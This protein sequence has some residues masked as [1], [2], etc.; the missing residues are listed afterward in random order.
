VNNVN[1]AMREAYTKACFSLGM[2]TRKAAETLIFLLGKPVSAQTVATLGR[3]KEKR[4]F[5]GATKAKK[6]INLV[7]SKFLTQEVVSCKIA[8]H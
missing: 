3:D 8:S 4:R 5:C 1:L 7:P 2:S 6:P